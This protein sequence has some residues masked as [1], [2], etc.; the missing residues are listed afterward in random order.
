MMTFANKT[1]PFWAIERYIN[2]RLSY[3]APGSKGRASRDNWS[4]DFWFA[5]R[6]ADEDSAVAT[7]I[8]TCE[9]EG[10][11]ASHLWIEYKVPQSEGGTR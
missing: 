7:L 1:D 5:A 6:F 3:Y 8:H 2:N 4:E 11:V 9:G 10:R